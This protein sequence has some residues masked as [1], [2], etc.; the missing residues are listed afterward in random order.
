M[1]TRSN[2]FWILVTLVTLG[3]GAGAVVAKP[4]VIKFEDRAAQGWHFDHKG[5]ESAAAKAGGA[6]GKAACADCHQWK[7]DGKMNLKG[8][9]EHGTRCTKCHSDTVTKCRPDAK[10][11]QMQCQSCHRFPAGDPC[12]EATPKALTRPANFPSTFNHGQHVGFKVAIEKD[13][14]NCHRKNAPPGS[15]AFVAHQRCFQCHG[16]KGNSISTKI[17]W[18]ECS[19]CHEA[20]RPKPP[21][22]GDPFRLGKF[23]HQKHHA[24]SNQSSCTTCHTSMTGTSPTDVPRPKMESCLKS[25]H[26]GGKTAGKAFSAVGTKCTSCHNS[27]GG[28]TMPVVKGV[29][30]SHEVHSKRNVNINDCASCHSVEANGNVLAPNTGK[31]H[32]PC[33]NPSCHQNEF[34]NRTTKICFVCHEDSPVP[35]KKLAARMQDPSPKPEFFENISHASHLQK[36]G[37]TNAACTDCHG[38]KLGGGKPPK[39]HAACS[40]CHGKGAPAHS[41]NECG[42]CH[43]LDPLTKKAP[44]DWSVAATFNHQRHAN[45]SRSRKNTNCVEC[46]AEIGKSTSLATMA[47]PKM[48][49]CAGCHN[50]KVS[51]KTTGF[52]CAKCHIKGNTGP[53]PTAQTTGTAGGKLGFFE[54]V[55]PVFS[56]EAGPVTMLETTS[57]MSNLR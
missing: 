26:D 29:V 57:G 32:A 40:Q 56:N 7:A 4:I 44:S 53:I 34:L 2:A 19:K 11:T 27:P 20:A 41:M 38:D 55:A 30:F 24:E 3:L 52:D 54:S 33:S 46:H 10:N 47:K 18:D 35:W 31:D 39:D 23:D 45:D 17:T 6:R 49:T 36:T 5:H 37:T 12:Y 13:C 43:K 1:V 9:Q 51:F 8:G 16:T 50:G 15:V 25:C 48:E 22:S 42:K 14:A 28:I 21:A